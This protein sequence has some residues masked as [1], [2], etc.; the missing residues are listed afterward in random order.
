MVKQKKTNRR[1]SKH[2][3]YIARSLS[4]KRNS[5]KT[6][7]MKMDKIIQINDSD[8][9]DKDINTKEKDKGRSKINYNKNKNEEIIIIKDTKQEESSSLI[10]VKELNNLMINIFEQKMNEYLI[11]NE[12]SEEE[13]MKRV[14][15]IRK[16]K[17]IIL[18]KNNKNEFYLVGSFFQKTNLKD[19]DIDITIINKN[20]INP[21]ID[22]RS[23]AEKRNEEIKDLYHLRNQIKNKLKYKLLKL[24]YSKVNIIKIITSENIYVDVSINKYKSY[25]S[26]I[27]IQNIIKDHPIL[28]K[29]FKII[30]QILKEKSIAKYSKNKIVGSYILFHLLYFFY[31]IYKNFVSN[32]DLLLICGKTRNDINTN[33]YNL[34][35]IIKKNG[36]DNLIEILA[37]FF[38]FY[39]FIF[40]NGICGFQLFHNK[41]YRLIENT[42]WPE[43]KILILSFDYYYYPEYIT[44]DYRNYNIL[45]MTCAEL[46]SEII[47]KI[48][49]CANIIEFK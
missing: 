13:T 37:L 17:K 3:T 45:K 43:D 40:D 36:G 49:T 16:L 44:R 28:E 33:D 35:E 12:M 41:K 26:G 32:Y 21:F 25:V 7:N 8:D 14:N 39:G 31:Q 24:I 27:I 11:K 38:Y 2:N 9:S 34:Q 5:S 48:K 15:L 1:K 4:T 20:Y 29:L 18:T 19:S 46:Y 22:K 42:D 6:K 30:K 47:E 10:H 23:N